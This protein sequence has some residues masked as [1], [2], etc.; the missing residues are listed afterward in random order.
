MGFVSIK[1]ENGGISM[2]S[3]LAEA[4]KQRA[5][6]EAWIGVLL[7]VLFLTLFLSMDSADLG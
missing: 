5:F 7:A 4:R 3:I 1:S 6:R 2:Q